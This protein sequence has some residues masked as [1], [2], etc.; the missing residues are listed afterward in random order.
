MKPQK[1]PLHIICESKDDIA[2]VVLMSGDPLRSKYIAEKYLD[3][4]KLVNDLRNMYAY[5]G[6]YKGKRITVMGHGM[7]VPSI[8]I[9]AF[10]LYYYFNVKKIIRI[11][12]GGAG[13]VPLDLNEIVLGDC[14]YSESSFG[15]QFNGQ[16]T[17][18]VKPSKKLNDIIIEEAKKEGI[19]LHVGN[20]LTTDVF[21][22]YC[23]IE[24]IDKRLPEYV[25]PM[26]EEMESFGLFTTANHFDREAA[27]IITIVDSKFTDKVVSPKDREQALDKMIV[28]GLESL[29]KS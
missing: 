5:T 17:H 21:T 20:I 22:P 15:L 25:T 4:Y 6:Y 29:I 8:G 16:L 13:V 1:E 7:G 12:T 18:L 28:L 26:V 11:G 14:A 2:D 24:A 27:A 9:Y 23:D 3:D 19:D 10:E